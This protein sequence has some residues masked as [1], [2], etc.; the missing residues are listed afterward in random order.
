VPFVEKNEPNIV[1]RKYKDAASFKN[2]AKK[3]QLT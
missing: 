2:N 3:Q 1:R